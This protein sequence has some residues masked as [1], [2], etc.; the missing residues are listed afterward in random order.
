MLGYGVDEMVG[1][2]VSRFLPDAAGA[3]EAHHQWVERSRQGITA[4]S[5]VELRR[6]DGYVLAVTIKTSPM[7]NIEGEARRDAGD[8]DR[9]DAQRAGGTGP[10]DG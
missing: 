6:K 9:Q 7:R 2:P 1:Q 4:E 8:A 3:L 5:E 10:A